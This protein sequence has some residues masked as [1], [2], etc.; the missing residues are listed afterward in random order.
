LITHRYIN[1]TIEPDFTKAVGDFV[2]SAIFGQAG[3]IENY[4]AMAVVDG[5]KIIAGVLYNNWHPDTGV[6]EMHAASVDKRWL[7]RPV[8]KAMFALPFDQLGCQ[9]CV[10]RVSEHN[11]PMLRIAEAYGFK[12]YHIPRLRGRDETEVILTLTDDDW[13]ASRFHKEAA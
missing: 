3:R 9:L 12:A 7:N 2:S 8:L 11:K 5:E 6:I 10:L 4:C 1:P 13:R